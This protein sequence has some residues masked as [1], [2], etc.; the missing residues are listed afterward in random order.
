MYKRQAVD[1]AT[2]IAKY[3][4]VSDR[5][6]GLTVVAFGTSLPELVTSTKAALRGNADIAVGNIVGSNIFN[7]LLDVYKRQVWK[8][9]FGLSCPWACP[10]ATFP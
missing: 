8:T 1:S 9:K 3:I 4:G 10:P 2:V 7:I 5:V 6:I